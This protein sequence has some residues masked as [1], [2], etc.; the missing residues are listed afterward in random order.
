MLASSPGQALLQR[1]GLA[2][3]LKR[4]PTPL[5]PGRA[6]PARGGT[7]NLEPASM[8]VGA[9]KQ[10]IRL[11]VVG[12]PLGQHLGRQWALQANSPS[13]PAADCPHASCVRFSF[14]QLG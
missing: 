4:G 10:V 14:L 2:V 12:L 1:T 6:S 8:F 7:A 5:V 9:G 13:R 11:T 3:P